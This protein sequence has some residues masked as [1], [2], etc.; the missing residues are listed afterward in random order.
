MCG[1]FT[2]EQTQETNIGTTLG[3]CEC[4]ICWA[5][6]G[7][8][9]VRPVV[10]APSWE[11]QEGRTDCDS[12]H[13]GSAPGLF[14]PPH[15]HRSLTVACSATSALLFLLRLGRYSKEEAVGKARKPII[16]HLHPRDS[17]GS[18]RL[19]LDKDWSSLLF[20]CDSKSLALGT[21]SGIKG[22]IPFSTFIVALPLH[23]CLITSSL[24]W[25]ALFWE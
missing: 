4:L 20:C 21:G 13:C 19:M 5:S 1:W 18:E 14:L 15:S 25:E 24:F 12:S 22:Q 17:G 7:R 11:W 2:I 6:V 8:H 3:A 16:Y 9:C 23:F 10:L